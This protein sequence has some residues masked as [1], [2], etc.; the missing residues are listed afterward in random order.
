MITGR[1]TAYTEDIAQHICEQLM[2]GRSL[3][4]ICDNDDQIPHRATVMRW[5]ANSDVE[6]FKS[7]RDK[8]DRAREVQY[9]LMIDDLLDIAD[10][11]RND[12]V[13]YLDD[14]DKIAYKINGEAVS[15]SRLRVD[16]RKWFMSKVLPKFAD[17]PVVQGDVHIHQI[18]PVPTSASVEDWESQAAQIHDSV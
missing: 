6:P 1:P 3:K 8:Y 11:G 14:D 15:R 16:T 7:F 5:L 10:D 12:Y 17:K 13:E 4:S 2:E 18:M 9:Q